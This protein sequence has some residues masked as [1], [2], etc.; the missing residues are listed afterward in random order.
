M[1]QIVKLP[2]MR[3]WLIFLL[4]GILLVGGFGCSDLQDL[5][6]NTLDSAGTL[7]KQPDQETWNSTILI[8]RDG[9][10]VARIWA[11][12]LASFN[13]EHKTVLKDSVAA[14]FFNAAGQHASR[15]TAKEGTLFQK[16]ER[17]VARGNVVVI[18]DS[19]VV[20]R[21]EELR[22]DK[23]QQKIVSD[24]PVTFTTK[25]D[26][27]MGDRFISDP[28]LTHFEIYNARGVTRRLVPLEKKKTP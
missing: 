10:P 11:A 8:T 25:T 1:K 23:H 20:L 26:T 3:L 6:P 13:K 2:F 9:R 12:Y 16:V 27:L 5:E 24:L 18:S 4:V 17:F 21:T 14:D 15:L 19:G 22:W 7:V 28:D